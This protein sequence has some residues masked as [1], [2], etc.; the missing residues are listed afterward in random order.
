MLLQKSQDFDDRMCV[1]TTKLPIHDMRFAEQQLHISQQRRHQNQYR[2]QSVLSPP[3][4]TMVM[5][6]PQPVP[7]PLPPQPMPSPIHAPHPQL[8]PQAHQQQLRPINP[9]QEPGDNEKRQPGQ[10]HLPQQQLP[11]SDSSVSI[12]QHIS[13]IHSTTTFGLQPTDSFVF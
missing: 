2:A 8:P 5:G 3:M 4:Y 13:P 7:P 9:S 6:I 10:I 1:A 11:Q 12:F